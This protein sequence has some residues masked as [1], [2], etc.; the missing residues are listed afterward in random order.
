MVFTEEESSGRMLLL[1][2]H[3]FLVSYHCAFWWDRR[4]K[5]GTAQGAECP[6]L[7]AEDGPGVS[8]PGSLPLHCFVTWGK[9]LALSGPHYHKWADDSGSFIYQD[10]FQIL[11]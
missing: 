10:G 5:K 2:K 4:T 6:L 9:M 7:L 11:S 8:A 3:S 1:Y